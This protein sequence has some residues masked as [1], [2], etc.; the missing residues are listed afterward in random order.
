MKKIEFALCVGAALFAPVLVGTSVA[1][2]APQ[3]TRRVITPSATWTATSSPIQATIAGGPWTLGQGGTSTKGGAYDGTTKGGTAD[4]CTPGNSGGGTPLMNPASAVNTFNPY[5]FPWVVGSGQNVKGYFDYRP[6]NINE[7]I[8]E[9]VSSNAGQTWTFQQVAEQ[10]TSECPNGDPNTA[11][12]ANGNP[13]GNDDGEGHASLI[14]FSGI[15]VLYTLDRRSPHVDADGLIMHQ[16]VPRGV[17]ALNPLPANSPFM[18]PP[19]C[20]AGV[21][22]GDCEQPLAPTANIVAGW[23]FNADTN[24]ATTF[25][26]ISGSPSFNVNN[27]PAPSTNNA[28]STP[29]ASALGMTSTTYVYST[30][31]VSIVSG[32]GG[33]AVNDTGTFG[34]GSPIATYTVTSVTSGVVIGVTV[35]QFNSGYT[36]GTNYAATATSGS[37]SGLTLQVTALAT[38]GSVNG[39]DV[40]GTTLSSDPVTSP[41]SNNPQAANNIAPNDNNAWR[42][43]GVGLPKKGVVGMANTGNGWNLAAPPC[44]QGAQFMVDTTGYH[45]IVLQFDWY[46]TRQG[47]RDLQVLYTTNGG[48]HLDPGWTDSGI[49]RRQRI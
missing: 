24:T 4:Y 13:A 35:S 38:T 27:S 7:A 29:T 36:I 19:A 46:T 33:Y 47:V 42:V 49:R 44:T 6:K 39:D 17:N 15:N 22:P 8:V 26:T 34:S 12:D 48:S 2:S 45:Y 9:A 40:T 14:S 10:L 32:G 25:T 3:M 41:A 21:A 28:A 5:Y 37:G 16:I 11:N 1:Q 30:Q 23:N 20:V 31:T 43:R 18:Q